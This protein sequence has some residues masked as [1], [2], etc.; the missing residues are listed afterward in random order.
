MAVVSNEQLRPQEGAWKSVGLSGG[1]AMFTP[2]ISPHDPNL[3]FINCDM[4]C[5]FRSTDGG[6]T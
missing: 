3:I 6:R 2:S 1:G 5:G 4:S